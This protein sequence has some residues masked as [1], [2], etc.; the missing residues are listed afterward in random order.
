VTGLTWQVKHSRNGLVSSQQD[1]NLNSDTG[2]ITGDVV[3]SWSTTASTDWQVG[4]TIQF[5]QGCCAYDSPY[6]PV[7]L[8]NTDDDY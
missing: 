5:V 6:L 1:I 8:W 7:L 4:D 3:G 2:L